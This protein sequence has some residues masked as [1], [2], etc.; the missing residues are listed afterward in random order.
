MWWIISRRYSTEV[1]IS[2]AIFRRALYRRYH[3]N[4]SGRSFGFLTRIF[5]H[6]HTRAQAYTCAALYSR[7]RG[8]SGSIARS[9]WDGIVIPDSFSLARF[10]FRK[11][12]RVYI[13]LIKFKRKKRNSATEA[14]PLDFIGRRTLNQREK[15]T[16][17]WKRS[18]K[19]Q[20][21]L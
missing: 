20:K 6:T 19:E 1:L 16:P 18:N 5:A 10:L 12:R 8:G 21:E 7:A 13:F 9:I 4:A 2:M 15:N 17:P 3:E 14:K 11:N